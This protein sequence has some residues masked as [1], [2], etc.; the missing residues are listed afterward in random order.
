MEEKLQTYSISITS[1]AFV[2]PSDLHEGRNRDR[3]LGKQGLE[4]DNRHLGQPIVEEAE[5]TSTDF[6]TPASDD[7]SASLRES[8]GRELAAS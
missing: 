7:P 3:N 8:K 4:P 2:S 5:A 1:R 6:L